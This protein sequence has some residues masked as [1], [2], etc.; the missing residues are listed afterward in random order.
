MVLWF[1]FVFE[2]EGISGISIVSWLN[3]NPWILKTLVSPHAEPMF[4][5]GTE[6]L[7]RT[8]LTELKLKYVFILNI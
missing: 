2:W 7:R 5:T 4:S 3:L 6:W 1:V 8:G